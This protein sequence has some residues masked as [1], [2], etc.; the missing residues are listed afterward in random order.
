MTLLLSLIWVCW[1]CSSAAIWFLR[2]V[3]NYVDWRVRRSWTRLREDTL[4][5]LRKDA[6]GVSWSHDI[7][8]YRGLVLL[9][10]HRCLLC[11]DQLLL[12]G[13]TIVIKAQGFRRSL[14]RLVAWEPCHA[15]VAF[16]LICKGVLIT[17]AATYCKLLDL[18]RS[19][20]FWAEVL[21]T[22]SRCFNVLH[23]ESQWLMLVH[24]DLE[25]SR[26]SLPC[27]L[28][29]LSFIIFSPFLV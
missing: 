16:Y 21:H 8:L 20:S 11:S 28:D 13:D 3:H 10:S 15:T 24:R 1:L 5:F 9:E 26:G 12:L 19:D 22:Q 4:G 17:V 25:R 23:Q 18:G 2:R 29:T 7:I 14:Q 27:S 6:L